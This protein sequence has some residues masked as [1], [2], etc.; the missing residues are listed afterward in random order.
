MLQVPEISNQKAKR[1]LS[2]FFKQK[3]SLEKVCSFLTPKEKFRFLCNSKKV[4]KE[5]DSKIDD[6]FMNREYQEKIKDYENYYEDL[7]YKLLMEKKR[8][9]EIK[10]EKIKL[11][12][13]ENDMVNYLKYLN[14]KFDKTIKLSLIKIIHMEPWKI[15]FIS[16]LISSLEKNIHLVISMDLKE[17]ERND[18]YINYLFKFKYE[19]NKPSLN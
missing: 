17:F 3:S 1:S 6:A 8:K 14:R 13:F 10:G 16:K 4:V 9:A 2:N 5:L 18:F 11:Y 12:E 19:K 15:D 7:F